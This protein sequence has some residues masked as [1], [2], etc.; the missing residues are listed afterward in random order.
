MEVKSKMGNARYLVKTQVEVH[1][2]DWVADRFEYDDIYEC[3]ECDH[4][5]CDHKG[6]VS[7]HE[8]VSGYSRSGAITIEVYAQCGNCGCVFTKQLRML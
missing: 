4:P 2:K 1:G 3:P 6:A 8:P 7:K 5:Y